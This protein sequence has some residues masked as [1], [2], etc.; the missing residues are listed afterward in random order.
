[1]RMDHIVISVTLDSRLI[2]YR[3]GWRT[4]RSVL[5]FLILG[6]TGLIVGLSTGWKIGASIYANK[7]LALLSMM[8]DTVP[9]VLPR[10]RGP[11]D[12]YFI[13]WW[14][15]AMMAT[16]LQNTSDVELSTPSYRFQEYIDMEE[17]RLR[18]NLEKI[19]YNIDASDTLT[20]VMGAGGLE[21]VRV[22]VNS[23]S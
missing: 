16:G 3:I 6:L 9:K 22:C 23:L 21:K 4:G 10:N 13:V 11:V 14:W 8:R 7:I 20:L 18:G 1:M 19:K 2:A 12:D 17:D 15:I 5:E